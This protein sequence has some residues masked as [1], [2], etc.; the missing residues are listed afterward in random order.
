M[1]SPVDDLPAS[2]QVG[3][4]DHS[5]RVGDRDELLRALATRP[6]R[7]RAV[8]VM[9]YYSGLSEAETADALGVS[10]GTLKTQASR[11]LDRLRTVLTAQTSGERIR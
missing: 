6:P 8:I 9:R 10:P 3:S 5:E 7:M 11:G 2:A 4:G 1:G